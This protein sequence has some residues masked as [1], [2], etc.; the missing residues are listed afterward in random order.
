MPF[1]YAVRIGKQPGVYKTWADCNAAV[2][3]FPNAKFKK[4][5][6]EK[7]AEAFLQGENSG[8]FGNTNKPTQP[9]VNSKKTNGG[10]TRKQTFYGR[11]DLPS[12]PVVYIA[13]Y[14]IEG[15]STTGAIGGIG[16]YWAPAH[17]KNVCEALKKQENMTTRAT[18]LIAAMKALRSASEMGLG[19]VELRTRNNH[20]FNS[21]REFLE[22]W[23]S[24]GW[25]MDNIGEEMGEI[26]EFCKNISITWAYVPDDV[27][28][29]G[30]EE[31]D[32][33][34]REGISVNF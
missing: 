24:N 5:N 21:M 13:S 14:C 15:D 16:V 10:G 29:F 26:A 11:E 9:N 4:F 12:S 7:E 34:A 17:P 33:L 18:E 27:S 25:E 19:S 23:Q 22:Q 32:R 6:T 28:C 20:T 8:S 30:I 2:K 31:A 1:Y 3:G